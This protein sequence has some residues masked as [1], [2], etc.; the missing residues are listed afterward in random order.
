MLGDFC[1]CW[2]LPNTL[3]LRVFTWENPLNIYLPRSSG[4]FHLFIQFI[5]LNIK[6][7]NERSSLVNLYKPNSV[8]NLI[9]FLIVIFWNY[10]MYHFVYMLLFVYTW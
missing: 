1:L 8:P 7:S 3:I 9:S 4:W 10:L 6:N 2:N 5:E